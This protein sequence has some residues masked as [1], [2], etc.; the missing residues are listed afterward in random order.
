M[1]LEGLAYPRLA[2]KITQCTVSRFSLKTLRGPVMAHGK[3]LNCGRLDFRPRS[4]LRSDVP[5]YRLCAPRQTTSL[6]SSGSGVLFLGLPVVTT[7][8]MDRPIKENIAFTPLERRSKGAIKCQKYNT[9]DD[10]RFDCIERKIKAIAVRARLDVSDG[11]R[12]KVL[13]N[14]KKLRDNRRSAKNPFFSQDEDIESQGWSEGLRNFGTSL[15]R[16]M[17]EGVK[18]HVGATE[19]LMQFMH[20]LS[21]NT[22]NQITQELH[23]GLDRVVPF[24]AGLTEAARNLQSSFHEGGKKLLR[25]LWFAAMIGV[26]LYLLKVS[27]WTMAAF[28]SVLGILGLIAGETFGALV[29]AIRDYLTSSG[30]PVSQSGFDTDIIGHIITLCCTFFTAPGGMD[31]KKL[32]SIINSKMSHYNQSVDGWAR[33]CEFIFTRLEDCLRHITDYLG[34][35]PIMKSTT[36]IAAV[37]KWCEQVAS[38][39]ANMRVGE[40]LEPDDV[41]FLQYLVREGEII[42]NKVRWQSKVSAVFSRYHR[43]LANL[44][45]SNGAAMNSIKGARVEPVTFCLAG[46]PGVGKTLLCSEIASYILSRTLPIERICQLDY[47]LTSEIFQKG[48]S[49]YWEGYTGQAG[50]V[51]DDFGQS[52][53]SVGSG[54]DNDYMMLVRMVNVWP[55]PLNFAD[56]QNKGRNFFRSKFIMMTTNV[57]NLTNEVSKVVN[58]RGAVIRRIHFPYRIG[59]HEQYCREGKKPFDDEALDIR[60]FQEESDKGE[61]PWHIWFVCQHNFDTGQSLEQRLT[62]FDQMEAIVSKM[63][64]AEA[65]HCSGLPIRKNMV[66]RVVKQR[67]AQQA[68]AARDSDVESGYASCDDSVEVKESQSGFGVSTQEHKEVKE[69]QSGF[70]VFTQEHKD[71]F[72]SSLKLMKDRCKEAFDEVVLNVRQNPVMSIMLG[73]GF[74][75]SIIGLVKLAFSFTADRIE[76]QATTLSRMEV[77][78]DSYGEQLSNT[79]SKNVLYLQIKDTATGR[80][81]NMGSVT[82]IKNRIVMMPK[83]FFA[84]VKKG[85]SKGTVT[86]T[87]MAVFTRLNNNGVN[88]SISYRDFIQLPSYELPNEPDFVCVDLEAYIGSNFKDIV[89]F[90]MRESDVTYLEMRD[91]LHVC[92]ATAI[93]VGPNLASQVKSG[94]ASYMAAG[95]HVNNDRGGYD[96]K[97]GLRYSIHTSLGDCGALVM[98]GPTEKSNRPRVILGFHTGGTPSLGNGYCVFV[99]QEMF[100]ALPNSIDSVD[101]NDSHIVEQCGKQLVEGGTF[102][103]LYK[104][105]VPNA[106]S[107]NTQIVPTVLHN[108]WHVSQKSP[109]R[110]KAFRDS[111]G[112]FIRP[113]LN[114]ISRYAGPIITYPKDQVERCAHVAFKPIFEL[115][116]QEPRFLL[117]YEQCVQGIPGVDFCDSIP[118]ST[119]AGYPYCLEGH[120]GKKKFFGGGNEYE[121]DGTYCKQ[122]F[123]TVS[124]IEED[125]KTGGRHLHVF[126]D[127]LKDEKRSFDK[128]AKGDTRLISA[129]PL[130]YTVLFRRYFMCFISSVM[131]HRIECGVAAGVNPYSEWN[132]LALYLRT[133]GSDIVAGDFKGFDSSEQ[134]QIHNSIL[135]MINQWYDDGEENALVRRVLWLEVTNSRHLGGTGNRNSTIYE[136]NKSLPSGHPG[137]TVINSFYNLV[138]FVMAFERCCGTIKVTEF[139]DNVAIN[140]LGDDNILAVGPECVDLFNQHTIERVMGDMGMIY[141]NEKKDGSVHKVRDLEQVDFLKRGFRMTEH[142]T[143][144]RSYVAPLSIDTILEM[145]YWCK[146]KNL[147]DEVTVET[148]ETAIMELSAHEASEWDTW[149]PKMFSAYK[150]AGFRPKLPEDQL[151]YFI[152]YCSGTVKY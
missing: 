106:I 110:L 48:S 69:P 56:L 64:R 95:F 128:N 34:V 14:I 98:Q 29:E 147:L 47:D 8:I 137:T 150:K 22:F 90:F 20:T 115:T 120:S 151:Q 74:F 49:E 17:T 4:L 123:E 135:E 18:V 71:F 107:P 12:I 97:R 45:E 46:A 13:N 58:E 105:D 136:W 73:S 130:A 93:Q 102:N 65:Y 152:K 91:S 35:E 87:C 32:A 85:V 94:K 145:P 30:Q 36:G 148:F 70:G 57:L 77:S 89:K 129:A 39:A 67:E 40:P 82:G 9:M 68:Q 76:S 126:V 149:A 96:V 88:F 116:R 55:F 6:P 127:F 61:F 78:G 5:C 7:T 86:D 100:K 44:C 31:F 42:A 11:K 62:L 72:T 83:H 113:M 121:F 104:I 117:T 112:V 37:D 27:G 101:L 43:E 60:K 134:P 41:M 131:R 140:V 92:L 103:S 143:N 139:W 1:L 109:A 122:L 119:S 3:S 38:M 26:G 59:V 10:Q 111:E 66:Y 23:A 51:M 144:G 81:I 138:L 124:R 28:S 118:R 99:T 125:A 108:G 21:Q 84:D 15:N 53:V 141:T 2:L 16:I 19:E 142:V 79:I 24:T 133:K 25:L 52:R 146:N 54:E 63:Q 80:V 33:M 75:V 50:V 114:A 132:D